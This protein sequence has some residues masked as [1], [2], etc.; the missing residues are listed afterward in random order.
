M[1]VQKCAAQINHFSK[2]S[3]TEI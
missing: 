2:S 1:Y 3:L